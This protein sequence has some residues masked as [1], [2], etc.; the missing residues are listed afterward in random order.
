MSQNNKSLLN[1]INSTFP[2]LD[3]DPAKFP[4]WKKRVT[5]AMVSYGKWYICKDE[6][7][8]ETS[9]TSRRTREALAETSRRPG[10]PHIGT[11]VP[12]DTDPRNANAIAG[13]NYDEDRADVWGFLL[14]SMSFEAQDA[15]SEE[16]SDPDEADAER[17]WREIH[18]L[19][20]TT[21]GAIAADL[22]DEFH[23]LKCPVDGNAVRHL[24]EMR[25]LNRQLAIAGEA[26]SDRTLALRM[27][28]SLPEEQYGQIK[29]N[30][31]Q[32]ENLTSVMVSN[33][34]RKEWR[35]IGSPTSGDAEPKKEDDGTAK[36]LVA[37]DKPKPNRSNK[38]KDKARSDK[39]V[40]HC[41]NHPNATGHSTDEC[42]VT[43]SKR[44]DE[45]QKK[46]D[47]LCK[48][49][50]SMGGSTAV[51]A[52]TV[53]DMFSD[54]AALAEVVSDNED[55]YDY[56]GAFVAVLHMGLLGSTDDHTSYVIDSGA[57]SHMVCTKK[58][59]SDLVKIDGHPIRTA[60]GVVVNA[61]HQGTL[62]LGTLVLPDVLYAPSLGF[63][64]LSVRLLA[65]AGY[66]THFS[67]DG[68]CTISD[69][70][71]KVVYEIA[72]ASL[73]H[74]KASNSSTSLVAKHTADD[75]LYLHRSLGHLNWFDV[76]WLG[77]HG[78]LGSE[79]TDLVNPKAMEIL[80][81]AC[82]MGKGYRLPSPPSDIHALRA[83]LSLHS[84]IWGP[85]KHKSIGGSRYFMVCYDDY[86]HHIEL[87]F[88]KEKSEAYEAFKSYLAL[89]ENQCNA[90]IKNVRS[91]NGGE[92]T[93]KKY[94]E[95]LAANGIEAHPVP[96]AAHAQNGRAERVNR[97]VLNIVRT[98]LCDTRLPKRFWAEAAA[99]AAYVRNHI[100]KKDFPKKGMT[101]TPQ[102]LWTGRPSKLTQLRPF[103]SPVFV[104]AHKETDKLEPRYLKGFL[105]G[106]RSYSENTIR[107]YDPETR[108]INHTRDHIFERKSTGAPRRIM[109]GVPTDLGN[110]K[111]VKKPSRVPAFLPL[112]TARPVPPTLSTDSVP[113]HDFVPRA[114]SPLSHSPDPTPEHSIADDESVAET[115]S[116]KSSVA[117]E[118]EEETPPRPLTPKPETKFAKFVPTNEPRGVF[119]PDLDEGVP[120]RITD[121][122]RR[123]NA[124]RAAKWRSGWCCQDDQPRS[125]IGR[126]RTPRNSR[127]GTHQV[128]GIVGSF[129]KNTPV[130]PSCRLGCGTRSLCLPR[131]RL[132]SLLP[133]SHEQSGQT[134]VR[135]CDEGRVSEDGTV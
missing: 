111:P 98:V 100:P 59:M 39:P 93:S 116:L 128:E 119:L 10:A 46:Y 79:W 90:K 44:Q 81:A 42:H 69:A 67:A 14:A 23:L 1:A 82:I 61:T 92:Y 4:V 133:R 75:I 104:L 9:A 78:F 6:E 112:S 29:S 85:T 54:A 56:T 74:L 86:T 80:C 88:L 130:R 47:E 7:V 41:E 62:R 45:L 37:N 11:R 108:T 8:L 24:I 125:R 135:S 49:L 102:E 95:L 91:D 129:H 16:A 83:H 97:T 33:A 22:L 26:V 77:R 13:R 72:G 32:S 106:Y 28:K 96:P 3:D 66:T 65:K 122:G 131:Y 53:P 126:S 134:E 5:Y 19:Y 132:P 12:A 109:D 113:D 25:N 17:V 70:D 99:Y 18:I 34:V 87:Y 20:D 117:D 68:K 64:L 105:M 36:A 101:S 63:N 52:E 120:H 60:G 15:L 124:P 35:R 123:V 84:D 21:D 127:N 103:G 38:P 48:K 30:L 40:K 51:L 2:I 115:A 110:K 27:L 118:P 121:D 58:H 57:S 94:L 50:E 76:W 114:A 89:V 43:R 71:G 31:F 55:S 73:Y 107:Y